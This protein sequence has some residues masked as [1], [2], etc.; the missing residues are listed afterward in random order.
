MPLIYFKSTLIPNKFSANIPI[1][2]ANSLPWVQFS[3]PLGGV[4]NLD[5]QLGGQ[6]VGTLRFSVM[7]YNVFT[8]SLPSWV[9]GII[10]QPLR[11]K[12][13]KAITLISTQEPCQGLQELSIFEGGNRL[14]RIQ[15]LVMGNKPR[16]L[17]DAGTSLSSR[18]LRLC[19]NPKFSIA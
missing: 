1:V 8:Q 17:R 2:I 12:A 11:G 14:V 9:K 3:T 13:N 18:G 5:I 4:G 15:L 7:T 10:M 16:H 6:E 19:Q